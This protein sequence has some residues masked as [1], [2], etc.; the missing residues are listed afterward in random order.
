M[1]PVLVFDLDDTLYPEL[2]YVHS[3]F[4][5]VA[6]M[7]AAR[8]GLSAPTLTAE[9]IAVEAALGRGRVFDEV[10]RTHGL[11]TPAAVRACLLAYRQHLPQLQLYPDA[12]RCLQRFAPWP[13][14]LVTDGHKGVQAR[15][16]A[17]LGLSGRV[18]HA[19]I[20]NRYGSHRAK[21]S[22]YCF[23]Q[24]CSREKVMPGQVLYVGDNPTKD[25]VGIRPLGFRTARILRG[26]YAHLPAPR[27]HAADRDIHSLDE[28][29]EDFLRELSS[30][31]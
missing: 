25:F 20:T 5:A 11:Y 16:V 17:A 29:T 22:P 3:G 6:T 28:L 13:L 31:P 14:Y 4:G 23:E 1:P 10:L 30:K 2:T 19:Y 12:E 27:T 21:P 24:I 26:N 9:M 18:R 7:L 15:K 8:F